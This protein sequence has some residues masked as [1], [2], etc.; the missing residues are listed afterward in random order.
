[1]NQGTKNEKKEVEGPYYF[2]FSWSPSLLGDQAIKNNKLIY[3]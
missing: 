3:L 2:C 1:V